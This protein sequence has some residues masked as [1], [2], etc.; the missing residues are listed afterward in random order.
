[1]VPTPGEYVALVAAR[2]AAAALAVR[3]GGD[4][5]TW[6]STAVHR[7]EPSDVAAG[8]R[9]RDAY[10]SVRGALHPGTLQAPETEV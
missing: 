1:V 4:P 3:D 8:R 2:Q 9:V 7:Q 6:S 5:P 10:A